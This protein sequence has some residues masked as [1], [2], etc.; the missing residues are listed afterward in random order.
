MDIALGATPDRLAD[1]L[2]VAARLQLRVLVEDV[3]TFVPQTWV[4]PAL[5]ES[6]GLR[7][8]SSFPGRPMGRRPSPAAARLS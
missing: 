3:E 8:I 4:L 7:W 5:D 6:S 1:A 2:E